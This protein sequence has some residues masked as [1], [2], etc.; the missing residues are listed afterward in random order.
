MLVHLDAVRCLLCLV[1]DVTFFDVSRFSGTHFTK[2]CSPICFYRA[3]DS[4]V[5]SFSPLAVMI[6]ALWR[7]GFVTACPFFRK[8]LAIIVFE[9][10]GAAETLQ[11]LG[12]DKSQSPSLTQRL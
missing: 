4:P 1:C 3:M 9:C 7:S 10:E 6:Y 2:R 8:K 12:V 11:I 5:M